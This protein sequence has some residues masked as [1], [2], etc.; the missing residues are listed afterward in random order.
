MRR[1]VKTTT[2]EDLIP[3]EAL[4][5]LRQDSIKANEDSYERWIREKGT[6]INVLKEQYDNLLKKFVDS[7]KSWGLV[8]M[9]LTS[10]T[11]FDLKNPDLNVYKHHLD[12]YFNTNVWRFNCLVHN[13]K[14]SVTDKK[15]Q[16]AKLIRP[17]NLKIFQSWNKEYEQVYKTHNLFSYVPYFDP[18][19]FI[20]IGNSMSFFKSSLDI[21]R[22][23]S[24]ESFKITR[25][26]GSQ[27][28]AFPMVDNDFLRENSLTT[29]DDWNLLR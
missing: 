22:L 16:D 17:E 20:V 9:L 4:V 27:I 7:G 11:Y 10:N 19:D 3:R 29:V 8:P 6:E 12:W 2:L 26:F 1:A 25:R 24:N 21:G 15:L 18:E 14:R 5:K 28:V 23:P 13:P